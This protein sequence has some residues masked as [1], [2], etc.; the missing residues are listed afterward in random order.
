MKH[1]PGFLS[2]DDLVAAFAVRQHELDEL[3]QHYREPVGSTNS[4]RMVIAPRGYG[5]TMLVRRV[6]AEIRHDPALCSV[7]LPVVFGEESYEVLSAAEFWHEALLHMTVATGDPGWTTRWEQLRDER[8]DERLLHRS[9]AALRQHAA[10][11]GLRLLLVVENM[12]ELFEQLSDTD[13]FSLRKVWMSDPTFAVLGTAVTHF[14]G[15]DDPDHANYDLFLVTHL[16]ALDERETD[17]LWAS[18]QGR[19]IGLSRARAIRILTGGNPRL[20]AIMASF[21]SGRTL[22]EL[23]HDLEHLIDDHSSYFKHNIEGIKAGKKRKVFLALADAWDPCTSGDIA[24]RARLEVGEVSVLLSRLEKEGRIEVVSSEG[25][26]RWYQVSERLYNLYYLLRRRGGAASRVRAV[27]DFMVVF[28]EP[29]QLPAI[30]AAVGQELGDGESFREELWEVLRAVCL[31]RY[32]E[33]PSQ[34]SLLAA[35]PDTLFFEED[36]P[37][38]LGDVKVLLARLR[39]S[40]G[41]LRPSDLMLALRNV[42][43]GDLAPADRAAVLELLAP[44]ATTTLAR[45]LYLHFCCASE[46]VSDAS[47]EHALIVARELLAGI[48]GDEEPHHAWYALST[49][50]TYVSEIDG[51]CVSLLVRQP[52]HLQL[53]PAWI[54][55]HWA[56]RVRDLAGGEGLLS[57]IARYRTEPTVV[58]PLLEAIPDVH[59]RG[60]LAETCL[61]VPHPAVV[62][63]AAECAAER[64]DWDRVI[65]LVTDD[66]I[67]AD[68]SGSLAMHRGVAKAALGDWIGALA[69]YQLAPV[70]PAVVATRVRILH[71]L[72]RSREELVDAFLHLGEAPPSRP[73]DAMYM[74]SAAALAGQ[75]RAALPRAFPVLDA[76]GW[77]DASFLAL[78][79]AHDRDPDALRTLSDYLV[80]VRSP[81]A[82][83]LAAWLTPGAAA[84]AALAPLLNDSDM[85]SKLPGALLYA[86]AISSLADP[87]A[88]EAALEDSAADARFEAVLVA[89]KRRRGQEV[90]VAQ[91]V[92]ALSD[93][94]L[95][96]LGRLTTA[97]VGHVAS[98]V[99]DA[100]P[101]PTTDHPIP[102]SPHVSTP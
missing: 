102:P 96:L 80:T 39:R 71:V 17:T 76:A 35:L 57:L 36:L 11:H 32:R 40:E 1:N 23:L 49:C 3:L 75:T 41:E 54:I 38:S 73:E 26:A 47:K 46:G 100:A 24:D 52:A 66:L 84:V 4:H 2:D 59:E 97:V 72:R 78:Y 42:W 85:V 60:R 89:L 22:R 50:S 27:I 9:L 67:C 69:D 12:D 18:V 58:A 45:Q 29:D 53:V 86:L 63:I 43:K 28:Y 31:E 56:P 93:D 20:V 64:E 82:A 91:E 34:D 74:L 21:A 19:P 55:R 15:I 95:A 6:A 79:R 99:D 90:H 83:I 30:V 37:E 5:K 25:R 65:A 77:T 14:P 44:R 81:I 7:W 92:R 16:T 8:D 62:L 94:V 33:H 87:L 61:D 48:A 101:A 88:V 70:S 10:V 68:G 98:L 51:D 13:A